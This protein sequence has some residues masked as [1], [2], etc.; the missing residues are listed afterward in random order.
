MQTQTETKVFLPLADHK[1]H[2][3]LKIEVEYDLGGHNYFTSK[4]IRRGYSV[5]VIPLTRNG[6]F[7]ATQALFGGPKESGFKVFLEETQRK[8]AKRLAE[9]T[10]K[11]LPLGEQIRDLFQSGQYQKVGE[12]IKSSI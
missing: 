5:Y 1:D 4:P 7:A 10:A 3:E 2:N 9:L 11:V 6:D 12:L 8:S